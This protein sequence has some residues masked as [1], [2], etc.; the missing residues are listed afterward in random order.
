MN[1]GISSYFG[2]QLP[3]AERV[4]LIR[5][6]GFTHT[7]IF[8][9]PPEELWVTPRR[10]TMP[11]VIREARLFLENLHVPFE[12]CNQIW[13]A[14]AADRAAFLERHLAAVRD[15]AKHNVDCVVL[16][17]SK[18]SN[19]PGPNEEGLEL[20][21]RLVRAAEDAGVKIAVENT[22]RDDILDYVLSR[23]NSRLLGLCYDS[24]H[25]W[26]WGSPRIGSLRNWG[27]RLMQTHFSDVSDGAD[28]HLLP[29]DGTVDWHEIA[30]AFPL[31]TYKGV[32]LL[33]VVPAHAGEYESAAAFL[34]EARE[35]L[36]WLNRVLA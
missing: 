32:R 5:D 28:R 30:A 27:H 13:S 17:L 14:N 23:I 20:F 7:S 21:R 26:L 22:R 6:T 12:D 25:D 33:E 35:R 15:A 34:S 29:R 3:L 18:G 11:D 31:E 16:H 4:A 9:G 10:D 8:W 36:E 24:S 19:E 1:L 2:Y